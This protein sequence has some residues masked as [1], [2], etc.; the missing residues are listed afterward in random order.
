[1]LLREGRPHEVTAN[2]KV[3]DFDWPWPS[4]PCARRGASDVLKM[5]PDDTHVVDDARVAGGIAADGMNINAR[6]RRRVAGQDCQRR[7]CG[8]PCF[9]FMVPACSLYHVRYSVKK[10]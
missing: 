10:L 8:I 1:M 5:R 7:L 3:G 9:L 4:R 6:P 2:F